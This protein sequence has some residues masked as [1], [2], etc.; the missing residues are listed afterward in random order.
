MAANLRKK[1]KRMTMNDS[2]QSFDTSLNMYT[3]NVATMYQNDSVTRNSSSSFK[4]YFGLKS[5]RL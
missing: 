4:Q 5:L 1:I 2:T 3:L